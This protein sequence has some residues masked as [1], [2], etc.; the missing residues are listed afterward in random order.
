MSILVCGYFVTLKAR[1]AWFVTRNPSFARDAMQ[2]FEGTNIKYYLR[3][4]SPSWYTSRNSSVCDEFVAK[5]IEQWP[6]ELRTLSNIAEVQPHAVYAALTHSL[7][8]KW[9]HFSRT[10]SY[11]SYHP[12]ANGPDNWILTSVA[13]VYRVWNL[14]TIYH[15]VYSFLQTSSLLQAPIQASVTVICFPPG[16]MCPQTHFPSANIR[17]PNRYH[18]HSWK[19]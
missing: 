8:S 14:A 9:S 4:S 7:S 13:E 3:W 2:T 19:H 5:N 6:T 17:P 11:I 16:N 10:I 15:G 1:H 12:L 18:W